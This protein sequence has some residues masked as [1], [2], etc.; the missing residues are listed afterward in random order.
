MIWFLADRTAESDEV[1][2]HI[3]V[4]DNPRPMAAD[5][6][7]AADPS[8]PAFFDP[9]SVVPLDCV[10]AVV[11][12]FVSSPYRSRPAAAAWTPGQLDGRR[13]DRPDNA[14]EAP[15]FT[16]TGEEMRRLRE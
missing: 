11:A 16:L 9:A 12:E 6:E 14:L 10:R 8:I 2:D 13:W 15:P 5:P 4:S 1:S 3:W 7:L